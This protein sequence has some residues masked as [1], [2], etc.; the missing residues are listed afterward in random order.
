MATQQA[1]VTRVVPTEKRRTSHSFV[2]ITLELGG[3]AY[4]TGV[5]GTHISPVQE[6]D[7]VT[8]EVEQGGKRLKLHGGHVDGMEYATRK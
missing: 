4:E 5:F 6:G 7:T 8:V 1:T 3:V 2:E